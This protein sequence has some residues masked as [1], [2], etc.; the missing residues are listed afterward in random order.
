MS[1]RAL[2]IRGPVFAAQ[3]ALEQAEIRL[4]DVAVVIEIKG[5]SSAARFCA[6]SVWNEAV[7]ATDVW[8]LLLQRVVIA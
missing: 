5:V 8:S 6:L 2:G 1:T 4:V 7:G 3:A